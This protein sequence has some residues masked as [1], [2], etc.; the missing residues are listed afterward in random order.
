MN[1][2]KPRK[3]DWATENGKECVWYDEHPLTGKIILTSPLSPARMGYSRRKTTI[4]KEMDRL[5]RKVSDQ[6]HEAN[7]KLIEKM[8]TRGE[9]YYAKVRNSLRQRL[10]SSST[11]NMEKAIIRESLRLMDERDRNAR[12]NEVH[13]ESALETTEA[14]IPKRTQVEVN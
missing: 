13:G 8:Q 1:I 2:I 6:E 9:P 12:K 4:P 5:F 7:A 11:S 3:E 14:P 10:Q